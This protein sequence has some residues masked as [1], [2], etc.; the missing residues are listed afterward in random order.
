M[1]TKWRFNEE[2]KGNSTVRGWR[3]DDNIYHA[4]FACMRGSGG[5]PLGKAYQ[6]ASNGLLLRQAIPSA[7]MWQVESTYG[8]RSKLQNIP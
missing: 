5:Y 8:P 7:E 2:Y 6:V 3:D 1:R 4:V